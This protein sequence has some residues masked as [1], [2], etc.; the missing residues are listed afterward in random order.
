M[1]QP[2]AAASASDSAE[3][4]SDS[5]EDVG[6]IFDVATTTTPDGYCRTYSDMR[7]RTFPLNKSSLQEIVAFKGRWKQE[8]IAQRAEIAQLAE[9]AP[10]LA[11]PPPP[12]PRLR[13]KPPH[14]QI[15]K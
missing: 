7:G 2:D 1:A 9:M 14:M 12:F 11:S 6:L 5:A 3:S 8:E 4:D 15:P 13:K 10:H